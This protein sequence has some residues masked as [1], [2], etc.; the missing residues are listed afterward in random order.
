MTEAKMYK[1]LKRVF[2]K[3]HYWN[4][5]QRIESGSTSCGIPDCY[6]SIN[7]VSGWIELK[8]TKMNKNGIITIPYRKGQQAWLLAHQ[9]TH[10]NTYVLLCVENIYLQGTFYFLV[11]RS[12]QMCKYRG[13]YELDQFCKWKSKKIDMSLIKVLEKPYEQ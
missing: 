9:R 4:K 7:G 6:Y 11:D 2:N 5:L 8:N 1:E 12:F 10:C 3:E 13:V